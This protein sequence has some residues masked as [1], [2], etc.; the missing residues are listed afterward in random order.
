MSFFTITITI[1]WNLA[2]I[3]CIIIPKMGHPIIL[4]PWIGW[5]WVWRWFTSISLFRILSVW[6][7]IWMLLLIR[8]PI[9]RKLLMV[10]FII[11]NPLLL[12]HHW[13]WLIFW[14][15]IMNSKI[16]IFIIIFL[17]IGGF[18]MKISEIHITIWT[19][20]FLTWI[21]TIWSWILFLPNTP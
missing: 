20:R 1:S 4:F 8:S 2:S 19:N 5:S 13:M 16:A 6:I 11:P 14:N 18:I 3:H 15:L 17:S 21:N 12:L 10:Y 9:M 7:R